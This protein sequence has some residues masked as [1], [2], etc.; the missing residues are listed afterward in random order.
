LASTWSTTQYTTSG[1]SRAREAISSSMKLASVCLIGRCDLLVGTRSLPRAR[2]IDA[3]GVPGPF[4]VRKMV[5][6]RSTVDELLGSPRAQPISS[7]AT[8]PLGAVQLSAF[9]RLRD[10]KHNVWVDEALLDSDARA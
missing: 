2:D 5:F 3:A 9:G 1:T 6:T 10:S 7:P 4:R 8:L